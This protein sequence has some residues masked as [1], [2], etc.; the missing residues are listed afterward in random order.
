MNFRVAAPPRVPAQ[1]HRHLL[2]SERALVCVRRHPAVIAPCLLLLIAD[3]VLFVLA[4]NEAIPRPGPTRLVLGVLIPVWCVALLFAITGWLTTGHELTSHRII[5]IKGWWWRRVVSYRGSDILG[6]DLVRSPLAR[7]CGY[8]TL[9]L[10]LSVPGRRPLRRRARFAPYPE[11][12][13]LEALGLYL[14][15]LKGDPDDED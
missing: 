13:Y 11:Q 14:P 10:T 9:V 2:P 3:V 15:Y 1:F 8:G 6:I 7:I 12:L 4:A 5:L